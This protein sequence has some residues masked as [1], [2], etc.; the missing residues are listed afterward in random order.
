MFIELHL[1]TNDPEVLRAM[2]RMGY[3]AAASITRV[4]D[5]EDSGLLVMRKVQGP[6]RGGWGQFTVS[7]VVGN[8]RYALNKYIT[9]DR[10]DVVTILPG[11]EYP[12][13]RQLAIMEGEGKYIE[14]VLLPFLRMGLVNDLVKVASDVMD[15]STRA[16]LSLGVGSMNDLKNPMDAAALLGMLT[17]DRGYWVR[18]VKD[19]P[20]ALVVDSIYRSGVCS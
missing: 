19:N 18:A 17:G 5:E 20:M 13:R 3:V 2:A 9:N 1:M 16:V 15:Y 7:Y 12:S 6:R 8:N 11:R 14:L 10:V 4:R